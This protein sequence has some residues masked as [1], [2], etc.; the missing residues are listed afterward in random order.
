MRPKVECKCMGTINN[1]EGK[2]YGRLRVIRYGG[3][4]KYGQTL[5]HCRCACGS[6]KVVR[7]CDLTGGSVRSCGC[8][9]R[10][11]TIKRSLK[12]GFTRQSEPILSAFYDRYHSMRY[13]CRN[14]S[15]ANYGG[16]GI[17][18]KWPTL[19]AFYQDMWPSFKRHVR[20]HGTWETT[21]DRIDGAQGYCKE[22]CR[23]TTRQKQNQ[24]KRTNILVTHRGK[25]QC[26]SAWARELGIDPSTIGWRL[27]HGWNGPDALSNY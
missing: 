2:I 14:K 15:D 27:R 16:E 10:D 25:T 20:K 6:T 8:L 13:R 21:I 5:W 26:I 17:E 23:W 3:A 7:S 12:H 19:E 24:N 18:C 4:N 22:N 11:A 9:H 1:K